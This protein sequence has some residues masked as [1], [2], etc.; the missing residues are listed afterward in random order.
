MAVG[1]N[2]LVFPRGCPCGR[3]IYDGGSFKMLRKVIVCPSCGTQNLP[4]TEEAA[5]ASDRRTKALFRP[6]VQAA[7]H[8]AHG[9]IIY[10]D[11]LARKLGVDHGLVKSIVNDLIYER[12]LEG[13]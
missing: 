4:M 11:V 7:F 6:E 1:S 3:D 8:V 2:E 12:K 13:V 9:G 10:T 5:I